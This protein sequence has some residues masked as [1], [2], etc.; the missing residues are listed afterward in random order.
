V[1]EEPAGG[2]CM[3]NTSTKLGLGLLI[4]GFAA[5]AVSLYVFHPDQVWWVSTVLAGG[6]TLLGTY[7]LLE[8]V[9]M[10]RQYRITFG[11]VP[12]QDSI[13]DDQV[14]TFVPKAAVDRSLR[15]LAITLDALC[16]LEM[17]LLETR[18][19]PAEMSKHSRKLRQVR[20]NMRTA[21]NA[22]WRAHALAKIFGH[23]T[24]RSYKDYLPRSGVITG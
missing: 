17:R 18:V 24:E 19:L 1:L 16:D 2:V 4:F 9:E 14:V 3:W 7:A 13:S 10:P 11:I 5:L 22:F 8:G 20:R 21:K 15:S 23:R 6:T 12:G